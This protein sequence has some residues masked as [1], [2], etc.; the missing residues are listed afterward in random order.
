[1]LGN[2]AFAQ[3]FFELVD[4][5]KTEQ[6]QAEDKNWRLRG[7]VQQELKY[8]LHTP[9]P[10]YD[11]A[12][13]A[14]GLSQVRTEIFLEYKHTFSDQL[15]T[16]VSAKNE[17]D[18][19]RWQDGEQ[20]WQLRNYDTILKDA[21]L[22]YIFENG[23]WTRLGN[24]VFAWGESES[25]SITDVLA[26]QDLREPG[27]A[28]LEDI[29][30]A[31]PA[32]LLSQPL[33]LAEA[34]ASLNLVITYKAGTDRYAESHED[35]YPLIAFSTEGSTAQLHEL[36]PEK[37]WE[38]ALLYSV[39]A[40]GGDYSVVFAE[41][42]NNTPEVF[43]LNF[44]G[45]DNII[46][47]SLMQRRQQFYGLSANK[48][49]DTL[50]LRAEFGVLEDQNPHNQGNVALM[51]FKEKRGMFGLEYNGWTDWL[52]GLEYNWLDRSPLDS[53]AEDEQ[54]SGL[55]L[56][57]QYI[58]MNEKLNAQFWYMKLAEEGG[59]ISRLSLSY[60]PFDN[61]EFSSAWVVY[62]NDKTGSR[63][64]PFRENDTLNLALKYGF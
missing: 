27:Q 58:S 11:F 16:Q 25:M 3:D 42:N 36:D 46:D 4:I 35:F 57:T 18:W 61:W 14:S 8:G 2:T 50:L 63:L 54:S 53:I 13:D 40:N 32:L 30:E 10:D 51:R 60:K 39:H 15:S 34:Q 41:I 48:V 17:I 1:M 24:Q 22:D 47:A 26:T 31:I 49:I 9:D 33:A 7:H 43:D 38:A 23:L 5:E 55:V 59:E 29:R 6:P 28:E 20:D 62:E 44:D 56:R 64:Y 45:E 21:Y 19:V 37:E 12:R 52:L